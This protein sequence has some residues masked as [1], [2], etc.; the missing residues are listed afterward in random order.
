[1]VWSVDQDIILVHICTH[2]SYKFTSPM[3]EC[4]KQ[5]TSYK[6]TSLLSVSNAS[7]R[8]PFRL[9]PLTDLGKQGSHSMWFTYQTS[10]NTILQGGRGDY[11]AVNFSSFDS[12][13][14]MLPV[15]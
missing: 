12:E 2:M 6:F 4:R 10:M 14:G 9:L 8:F 3:S 11:M 13:L 1:M 15:S 7:G 5:D